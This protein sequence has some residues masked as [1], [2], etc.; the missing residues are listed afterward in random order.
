[1]D[2]ALHYLRSQKRFTAQLRPE[3]GDALDFGGRHDPGRFTPNYACFY[4]QC[5]DIHL[6]IV[7]NL[8]FFV[9]KYRSGK[10]DPDTTLCTFLDQRPSFGAAIRTNS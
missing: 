7:N 9:G 2:R 3:W 6:D 4:E 1:V 10:D 8:D 5:R